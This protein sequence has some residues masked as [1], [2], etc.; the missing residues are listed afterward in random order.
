MAISSSSLVTRDVSILP[1]C[2]QA[3][4]LQILSQVGCAD[5]DLNCACHNRKFLAGL[6]VSIYE[7]CPPSDIASAFSSARKYCTTVNPGLNANRNAELVIPIVIFMVLA[8]FSVMLRFYARRISKAHLGKDDWLAAL[9]L[10]FG[11]ATD[12]LNLYGLRNGEGHHQFMVDLNQLETSQKSLLATVW[13][14]T[15]AVLL[16]KLAVLAL[17]W[18]LFAT[19]TAY[20]YAL[21]VSVVIV[22]VLELATALIYTLSCH[23]FEYFWNKTIPGGSC[24]NS[25]YINTAWCAADLATGLWVLILPIPVLKHLH[26]SSRKKIAVAALFIVGG[27]VC[28]AAA[29]RIPFI[30]LLD[31]NDATWSVVPYTIWTNLEVNVGYG[32]LSAT[33]GEC[34]C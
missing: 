19:L 34:W 9:S 15:A 31:G 13:T 11:I 23:P 2:I 20:R 22:T 18:R 6:Q 14:L 16:L 27:F 26:A 3:P 33:I 5:G 10:V 1:Q 28:V 32:V 12:I 7:S 29:I 25:L 4:A 24:L 17:Y 8:I 30:L 21:I